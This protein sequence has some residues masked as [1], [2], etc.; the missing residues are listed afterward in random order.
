M[1]EFFWCRS[2]SIENQISGG[3]FMKRFFFAILFVSIFCIGLGAL[4]DRAGA[5][6]KSDEKALAL[7][8]KAR[9]AIG[10]DAAIANIQS[11]VIVGKTTRNIMIDGAQKS[12]EGDT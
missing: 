11:M 8:Q 12:V 9:Q 6:F 1:E 7:I 4:A 10:G 2:G 5:N 3:N